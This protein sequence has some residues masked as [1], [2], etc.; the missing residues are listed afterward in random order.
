VS[1]NIYRF[2]NNNGCITYQKPI[3]GDEGTLMFITETPGY[4]D[5]TVVKDILNFG[6]LTMNLTYSNELFELEFNNL[7]GKLEPFSTYMVIMKWSKKNYITELNIYK[8]TCPKDIPIYKV[9]PDMY[10]FDFENPIRSVGVYNNDLD[11]ISEQN[12]QIHPYPLMMSNIKLY[13]IM[14]NDDD[15]I[16]ESIKYVTNH[17]SCIINDLARPLD[18]GHG[19]AVR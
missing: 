4:L 3:C 11:M 7:K 19:Y 17:E 13:N 6:E 8:Y 5:K 16:K 10:K 2:R 1:R 9:R 18:N 14:L 12:C 15:M